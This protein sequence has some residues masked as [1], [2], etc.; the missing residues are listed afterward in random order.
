VHVT[1]IFIEGFRNFERLDLQEL[2]PAIVLVGENGAGKS[3]L[4][5]ALR[6]VFDPSLPDTARQLSAE[7]FWDGF[8]AP[9][10]GNVI[11]VTVELTD[12]DGDTDAK[13]LLGDYLVGTAPPSVARLTYAYR[14]RPLATSPT[15]E[16]DYE[17]LIYG[18]DRE[19]LPVGREVLRYV[20]IRVLPA[21]RDAESDLT[22]ARSPLRRLLGRVQLEAARL[23]QMEAAIASAGDALLKDKGV[24][25]INAGINTR[26]H[27][28]VGNVFAVATTLGIAP[29]DAEQLTRSIRLF[30]NE[31]KQRTVGQVS[32]GTANLLYLALLLEQ[33]AAQEESKESVTAILGVEEPEAHLHPHLQ[34]VLF[35]HLL[36]SDR[37][38]I[39]TTHS[40][41]L[42][43]VSPLPSLTLLRDVGGRTMGFHTRGLGLDD[44]TESD[45]ARY[46]RCHAG[47]DPLRQGRDPS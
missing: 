21:L 42:A 6:L 3:N 22:S 41:H 29:T 13:A 44:K 43:S 2:P 10:A 19:D 15:T 30:I 38:L 5:Y 27:D 39:V 31:A 25:A 36:S 32:L 1:R 20:S 23:V 28:M 18:A 11:S 9:F 35:R 47:R 17:S 46:L 24:A 4:L 40:P 8:S 34:R 16:A 7:D 37:P 33:L 26:L 45:L 12:F 14:P